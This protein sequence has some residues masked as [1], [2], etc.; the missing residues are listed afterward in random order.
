[1]LKDYKFNKFHLH[2]DGVNSKL[3][4]IDYLSAMEQYLQ[5]RDIQYDTQAPGY[6]RKNK[7]IAYLTRLISR[8]DLGLG[9]KSIN[10][11]F[12]DLLDSIL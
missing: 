7:F 1:M 11:Y 4:D 6:F 10:D 3:S 5:V 8:R 2:M 12:L 9:R